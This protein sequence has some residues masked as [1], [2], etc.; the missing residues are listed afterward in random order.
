MV[1]VQDRKA[2]TVKQIL[3]VIFSRHEMPK[4]LVFENA[5]EFCDETLCSWLK[6][7]GWRH[8]KISPYCLQS[9]GIVER[10]VKM[11]KMGF[12]GI[13]PSRDTIDW[14]LLRLLLNYRTITH[15]G[16]MQSPSALMRRQIRSPITMSYSINE[17]NLVQKKKRQIQVLKMGIIQP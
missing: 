13:S 3:Q 1:T 4:P 7:I 5:P 12:E 15:T 17:G 10:M 6:Q 9:N 16:R 14:Y 2:A 11:V 8:Y